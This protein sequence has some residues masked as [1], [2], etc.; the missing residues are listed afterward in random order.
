MMRRRNNADMGGRATFS[1]MIDTYVV[2]FR[3]GL[4]TS[5]KYKVIRDKKALDYLM[6]SL[7]QGT[8]TGDARVEPGYSYDWFTADTLSGFLWKPEGHKQSVC[9]FEGEE[10]ERGYRDGF[11]AGRHAAETEEGLFENPGPSSLRLPR[12]KRR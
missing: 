8:F 2:P 3:L 7:R 1:V 9:G 4:E 11:A 12:R 6:A 10:Y 5:P